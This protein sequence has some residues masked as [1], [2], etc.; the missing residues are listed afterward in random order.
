V[1]VCYQR[2]CL[3]IPHY[4]RGRRAKLFVIKKDRNFSG[5]VTERM[6]GP[7]L[8][9]IYTCFAIHDAGPQ[10]PNRFQTYIRYAVFGKLPNIRLGS[11][12]EVKPCVCNV[13]FSPKN[14]HGQRDLSGLKSANAR[15]RTGRVQKI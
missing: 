12:S 10:V 1:P 13:G 3:P 15:L 2:K 9:T 5:R 11:F 14:G 4:K 8:H 7:K 6:T